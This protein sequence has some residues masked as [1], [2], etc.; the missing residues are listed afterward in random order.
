MKWVSFSCRKPEVL[1]EI[2]V[3]D[4]ANKRSTVGIYGADKKHDIFPLTILG[5]IRY[6]GSINRYTHWMKLDLYSTG[7]VCCCNCGGRE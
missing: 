1:V 3:W 5:D 2:L 7:P 6:Y 4:N